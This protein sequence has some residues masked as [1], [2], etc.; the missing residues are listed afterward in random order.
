MHFAIWGYWAFSSWLQLATRF[1]R[2]S[3]DTPFPIPPSYKLVGLS[4]RLRGHL[5]RTLPRPTQGDSAFP[6]PRTRH[7][8]LPA[9]RQKS[10]AALPLAS[11][12]LNSGICVQ[13]SRMDKAHKKGR[14][15]RQAKG[16]HGG[17]GGNP[18][19]KPPKQKLGVAAPVVGPWQR[20]LN[21][22]SG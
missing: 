14:A 22:L 1:E 6:L 18:G 21:E 20:Q 4:R 7:F 16:M 9:E 17:G 13:R 10:P 19:V 3:T 15:Q 12:P 5:G 8:P 11:G 2:R